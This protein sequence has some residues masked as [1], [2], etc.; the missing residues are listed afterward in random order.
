MRRPDLF[1]L[2]SRWLM[3]LVTTIGLL[4]PLVASAGAACS[5]KT[6]MST[7]KDTKSCCHKPTHDQKPA[8]PDGKCS[9]NC[10]TL[11]CH[12]T[13]L[14]DM[15]TF[16]VR[17]VRLARTDVPEWAA[18]DRLPVDHLLPPPRA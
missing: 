11:C 3:V 5:I 8:Q 16:S 9:A 18:P 13:T 10:F 2:A 15:P 7:S 12:A 4:T 6:T 14:P 1:N 17:L